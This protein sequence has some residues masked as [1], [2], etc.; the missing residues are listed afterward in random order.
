MQEDVKKKIAEL[1][2]ILHRHNHLYYVLDE[3]EV[4]DAEYDR[5]MQQLTALE[6]AHPELITADSPTQRVGAPPLEKFETVP[7]TVPMLSLE[8]AFNE[9]EVLAFD[10]WEA[11]DEKDGAALTSRFEAHYRA[12]CQAHDFGVNMTGT[13]VTLIS[14]F[15]GLFG[16]DMLLLA[17]GTDQERMG[18]LANRYASWMQQ[19]YDALAEADVPVVIIHDD[20]VWASGPIFRP[21]WYRVRVPQL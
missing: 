1:R 20:I 17:A 5:L 3:P 14:G 4:S 19:Y 21:A 8:N 13:Y 6:T 7:H 15:I 12:N 2:S 10:P 16:W 9:K 11:L 18:A